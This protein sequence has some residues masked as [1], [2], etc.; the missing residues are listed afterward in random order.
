MK[1]GDLVKFK[2]FPKEGGIIIKVW[3]SSGTFKVI[4]I[5]D[6]AGNILLARDPDAFKVINESR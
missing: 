1:V 3:N 4:D 2:S 6:N 5:L